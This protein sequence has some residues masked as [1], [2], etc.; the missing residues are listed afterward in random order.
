MPGRAQQ[1]PDR[2]PLADGHRPTVDTMDDQAEVRDLASRRAEISPERAG[3]P[4][5]GA[6]TE[7]EA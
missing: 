2:T 4:L 3:V 1:G 5:P 6:G 7:P